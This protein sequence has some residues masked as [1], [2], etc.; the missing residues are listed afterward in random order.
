MN[1]LD[2]IAHYCEPDQ[3]IEEVT[4][5]LAAKGKE[6]ARLRATLEVIADFD[7]DCFEDDSCP[8][9]LARLALE[10]TT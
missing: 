6:I 2:Y 4:A 10:M 8:A 3:I 5:E 1:R 9:C 7:C